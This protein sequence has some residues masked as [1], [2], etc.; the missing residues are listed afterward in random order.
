LLLCPFDVPGSEKRESTRY[1]IN[2]IYASE[3]ESDDCVKLTTRDRELLCHTV[4]VR[5]AGIRA[6][7]SQQR[8]YHLDVKNENELLDAARVLDAV[9]TGM[10]IKFF[11][12]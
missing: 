10:S 12:A 8:A 11:V 3:S 1:V 4:C 2:D 7:D 5:Q 6:S 9:C